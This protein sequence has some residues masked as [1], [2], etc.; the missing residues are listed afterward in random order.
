MG[1]LSYYLIWMI[2]PTVLALVSAHP[3]LL[4]LALIAL[5]AAVEKNPKLRYGDPYLCAGDALAA[6]G[7]LDE[8]EDAYERLLAI[9]PSN[10]EGWCKLASVRARRKDAAGHRA[11][12]AEAVRTFRQLP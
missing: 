3:S 5:V 12:L 4:V 6:L 9:N 8:A 10:L 1:W 11:A 7:R 2:A